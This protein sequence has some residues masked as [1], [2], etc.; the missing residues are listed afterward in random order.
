MLEVM[1][2]VVIN[3]SYMIY[4]VHV[5]IVKTTFHC[6]SDGLFGLFLQLISIIYYD[7][8]YDWLKA[9]TVTTM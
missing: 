8:C 7:F 3:F 9:T 5:Y 2:Y 1:V 6:L 4:V